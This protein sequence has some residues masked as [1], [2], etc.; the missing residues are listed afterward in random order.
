MKR[1]FFILPC[2]ILVSFS[3][4]NTVAQS[5]TVRITPLSE[6]QINGTSNI[7]DFTCEYD[8]Q[9]LN[10]PV[11]IHYEQSRNLIKFEKSIIVLKNNGF[12]CGG[13]GINRDFH[14]LLQSDRYPKITLILKEIKLPPH[15][16][17]MAD[18]LI[19]IEIAGLTNS[20]HMATTFKYDQDWLI[21]GKLK[22]NIQDFKLE[23]PKKM[24]GLVIVSDE[25]EID[26]KLVV[27]ER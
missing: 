16:K 12:D 9:N 8:I 11:R 15:K 2:L 6:L 18:A 14:G 21:S 19:D 22:L 23:A 27:A 3:K 20:Y 7:K 13:R 4:I 5:K 10:E 24:F 17:N 25:I 26:F 1:L